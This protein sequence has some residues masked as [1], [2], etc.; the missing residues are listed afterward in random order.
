MSSEISQKLVLKSKEKRFT[1]NIDELKQL[2]S[3]LNLND[4]QEELFNILDLIMN[5]DFKPHPKLTELK[6]LHCA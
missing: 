5:T 2:Y 6:V 4:G 3:F 1:D